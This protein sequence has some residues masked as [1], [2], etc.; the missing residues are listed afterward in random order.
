MKPLRWSGRYH[1]LNNKIQHVPKLVKCSYMVKV[2]TFIG[3]MQTKI[4]IEKC[5]S[6]IDI[7]R[8]VTIN[9]V[10]KIDRAS[11]CSIIFPL[12]H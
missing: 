6:I 3:V 4:R 2:G 12:L 8:P 11:N 1:K 7:K 9:E 10:K 5:Q